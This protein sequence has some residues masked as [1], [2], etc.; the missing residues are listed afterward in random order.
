[1]FPLFPDPTNLWKFVRRVSN[2]TQGETSSHNHFI[3]SHNAKLDLAST[4]RRFLP[5]HLLSTPDMRLEALFSNHRFHQCPPFDHDSTM[6]IPSCTTV[7]KNILARWYL[8]DGTNN[9]R[10][11]MRD[12]QNAP[13][14]YL[15]RHCWVRQ[16]SR[17]VF[18]R[19]LPALERFG[20][21]GRCSRMSGLHY[22]I[23]PNQKLPPS[24]E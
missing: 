1:M 15:A 23:K 4:C 24:K 6:H 22:K 2:C 17:A 18:V 9:P 5:L 20:A 14:C 13:R 19:H 8:P 10:G 12:H 11:Y 16:R 3:C 7:P 21:V